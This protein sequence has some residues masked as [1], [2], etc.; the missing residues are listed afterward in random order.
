[1]VKELIQIT[2]N[3]LIQ[4]GLMILVKPKVT[5]TWDDCVWQRKFPFF[6]RGQEKFVPPERRPS[7]LAKK[8]KP[9]FKV[10]FKLDGTVVTVESEAPIFGTALYKTPNKNKAVVYQVVSPNRRE[11]LSSPIVRKGQPANIKVLTLYTYKQVQV[12]TEKEAKQEEEAE[13]QKKQE[14]PARVATGV[15]I[16]FMDMPSAFSVWYDEW[17]DHLASMWRMKPY[18]LYL[19]F[20]DFVS[21]IWDWTLLVPAGQERVGGRKWRKLAHSPPEP[22]EIVDI[23]VYQH[24]VHNIEPDQEYINSWYNDIQD[25][26]TNHDL[27]VMQLVTGSLFY[28]L[29]AESHTTYQRSQ[30]SQPTEMPELCAEWDD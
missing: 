10:F 5:P 8:Q 15:V 7:Y 4:S 1:M 21:A 16:P 13:T 2:P 22:F 25:Y 28:N 26:I 30:S 29:C 12:L 3:Q 17:V 11:P 19:T 23:N 18:D 27:K 24:P 14:D 9:P 6:V 20:D